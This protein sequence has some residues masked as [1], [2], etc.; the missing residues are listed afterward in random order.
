MGTSFDSIIDL[1]LIEI[2][3]YKLD[4]LFNQSQDG[5]QTYCDGFLI[6]A[7]PNFFRCKQDL[8]YDANTRTFISDLTNLEQSILADFWVIQWFTKEV[9]DATSIANVLQIS[10]AFST[11]SPASALKEKGTYLNYLREKV[12]QK[13][14]LYLLSDIDNIPHFNDW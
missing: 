3:D 10:S 1:A 11:H 8:S 13:I 12:M 14:N 4:K 6:S 9:Q 5:F 7:I 2:N